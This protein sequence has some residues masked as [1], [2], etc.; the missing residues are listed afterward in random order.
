MPGTN[1]KKSS[2]AQKEEYKPVSS[3]VPNEEL[4]EDAS[5][6]DKARAAAK[7]ADEEAVKEKSALLKALEKKE[8]SGS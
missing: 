4:P 5:D 7:K 1:K 6:M 8:K 3:F 2:R